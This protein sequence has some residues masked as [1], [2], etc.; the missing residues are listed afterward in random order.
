MLLIESRLA[1]YLHEQPL[2][3]RLYRM[4]E[5]ACAL[6]VTGAIDVVTC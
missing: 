6:D 2:G 1:Y 3:S 4:A 5:V